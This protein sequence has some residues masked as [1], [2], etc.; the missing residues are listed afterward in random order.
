MK[1][2]LF[3]L[4][5][6]G[7]LSCTTYYIPVESFKHQLSGIDSSKLKNVNLRSPVGEIY[8]YQANP[9]DSIK[10]VDKKNKSFVLHNGPSIE[11]RFTEKDNTKTVFYF[12]RII[13]IDT[14]IIGVQS[15]FIETTRKSIPINNVKLIEIENGHKNFKYVIER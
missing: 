4:L 5:I 11:I 2:F 6:L 12:D 15:R 13:L 8:H 3:S 9:F 10:C 1:E 7:L 14:M